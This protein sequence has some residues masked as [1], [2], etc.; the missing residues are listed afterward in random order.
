MPSRAMLVAR[1]RG[2]RQQSAIAAENKPHAG[3]VA[4]MV[5]NESRPIFQRHANRCMKA[6]N[7]IVL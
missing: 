5:E 4:A 3:V 6:G 7:V 1:A 2:A